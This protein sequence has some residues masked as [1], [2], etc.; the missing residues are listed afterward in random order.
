M[1][2]ATITKPKTVELQTVQLPQIKEDEVKIKV[3]GCGICASS[4]PLWEGREWFSYP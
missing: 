3:Q 4:I 2:A 1:I